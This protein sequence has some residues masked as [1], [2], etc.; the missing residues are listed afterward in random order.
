M[1]VKILTGT[2]SFGGYDTA[3]LK[4]LQS[5]NFETIL[6]PYKRKLTKDEVMELL[7]GIS[8]LIAG[9]EP[10]DAEVLRQSELKVI[11]RV[12]AGISNIDLDV[13]AQLGIKVCATPDAPTNAVA[14]LTVAGILNCLRQIPAMDRD[15]H[16]GEWNRRNGYQLEGKTVLIVGYG[17]IGRRVAEL[18]RPFGVK[19]LVADPLY[20]GSDMTPQPLESALPDADIV[21]FHCSGEDCLLTSE[22]FA[23]LKDGVVLCNAA[24]GGLID[25]AALISSLESGQTRA[26]WLDTFSEEPYQGKLREFPQAVLTP[27]VGSFTRECR[28]KMELQAVDNLINALKTG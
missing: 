21:T 23:S 24:R 27:H 28:I 8:G 13:A 15:L 6:N 9:L 1:S 19:L 20:K 3:P 5:E 12:G 14:E 7:P 25:E 26:C 11:S 17:R 22:L 18:L 4:R 2:S 10:L 16:E